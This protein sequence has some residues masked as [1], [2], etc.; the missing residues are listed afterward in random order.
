MGHAAQP[1]AMRYPQPL[2]SAP[3][4]S[5]PWYAPAPAAAPLALSA[6]YEPYVP[7]MPQFVPPPPPPPPAV[8]FR[9]GAF[10]PRRVRAT[11][12]R[13]ACCATAA[14][15]VR[16]QAA[17][18]GSDPRLQAGA[19]PL[20]PPPP[21]PPPVPAAYA[22]PPV[23]P[24]AAAWMPPPPAQAAPAAATEPAQLDMLKDLLRQLAAQQ[25][26]QG[27]AGGAPPQ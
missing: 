20:P 15:M 10:D 18:T 22:A 6:A 16:A 13:Y 17:A 24:V 19:Q 5:T 9:T 3:Q 7:Q 25:A 1:V 2:P 23:P 8:A 26:Q 21:M 11:S 12:T 4:A 14:D 27:A